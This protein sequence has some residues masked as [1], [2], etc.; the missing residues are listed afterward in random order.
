MRPIEICPIPQNNGVN[1]N[2]PNYQEW[3]HD[4]VDVYGQHC[5]YC[6]DRLQSNIHVEHL[7]AKSL[8]IISSSDWNNLFLA[9]SPCN[10]AKYTKTVDITTHYLP[11]VHNTQMVFSFI[12]R[13]HKKNSKYA[14]IPIPHPI[15]NDNQKMKAV[16]TIKLI[17]LDRVEQTPFKERKMTDVRWLNRFNA[18][19]LTKMQRKLWETL[20]TLE[21]KDIYLKTI[22]PLIIKNGF[23]SLW[24]N[25]FNGV[26][27]VLEVII[28]A[29]PNTSKACFDKNFNPIPRNLTNY[30]DII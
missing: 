19:E 25:A 7:E 29:F 18:F 12:I 24:I 13:K 21:Q 2:Y 17:E 1:K 27:A 9:C 10:L 26:P 3:K 5:M 6:N 8:G 22:T 30:K 11:N 23:F 28:N 20:S 4:L 14:C 15:L 16:N